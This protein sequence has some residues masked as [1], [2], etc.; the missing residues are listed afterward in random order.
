MASDKTVK[1]L[2][3]FVV[4]LECCGVGVSGLWYQAVDHACGLVHFRDA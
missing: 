4:D 2:Q 3:W 1:R